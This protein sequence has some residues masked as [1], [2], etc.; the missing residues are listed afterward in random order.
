VRLPL[1]VLDEVRLR[2]P[3]TDE[4][5]VVLKPWELVWVEEGVFVSELDIVELLVA[6]LVAEELHEG[7]T[8]PQSQR[9]S[10]ANTSL[11]LPVKGSV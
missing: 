9:S 7:V 3:V 2:V 1:A 10:L 6:V 4:E 5:A 8:L 11:P